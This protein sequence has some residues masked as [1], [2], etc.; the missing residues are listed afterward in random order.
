MKKTVVVMAYFDRQYQL[1]KTLESL[2]LSKHDNFS[3]VIVDDGSPN[4]INYQ[5]LPFHVR[6]HP[7]KDKT[8]TNCAP[9]YNHGFNFALL[10]NPDI[11]IIQSA[12]CY[13]I[14]D[15]LSH[16]DKHITDNNY[17]AFGCFRLDKETTF[18][19]HNVLQLSKECNYRVDTDNDGLGQNAWWNHPVYQPLP[20]YWCG[21]ITAK[22]LIKLNG[23]D[24]RFAYGHAFEDGYFVHQV[25]NLGLSTEI[26]KY[27][28]VVH[29]WHPTAD[30]A[31]KDDLYQRNR[32][33]YLRLMQDREYKAH[34]LITQDLSWI[35]N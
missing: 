3:V 29:Q 14:G 31:G 26:T 20:Q 28:F 18:K 8:W 2:A 33:L 5:K 10:D 25:K 4:T 23:I 27:P 1:T 32:S 16:A 17:I 30:F 21:A 35:G 9:V 13:H 12:E 34:H 11:I 6:V 24:E 15:V 22:N 19:K 7:L